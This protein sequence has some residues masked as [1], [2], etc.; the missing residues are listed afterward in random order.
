MVNTTTDVAILGAGIF[1]LAAALELR[2]RGHQVAVLDPGPIPHPLASTTDV[3]K[4]VRM[5]YGADDLYLEMVDRAIDGFEVWNERADE[6][7]YHGCGVVM[8][9]RDEMAPG[10]F[11]HD[12]YQSLL[13]HGMTPERLDADDIVR[14]FPA[15][16]PGAYKD[17]F[18]HARGGF[19]ES[20]RVVETLAGWARQ[21]GVQV[22]EGET[23]Q[24]ID[25]DSGRVTGVRTREGSHVAAGRVIIAAGAWTA[26][27]L[28]EL[29]PVMKATGHP[30]FHLEAPDPALFTPPDFAVFTADIARTGWYGF[31]QHPK[32]GIVKVA[33]HSAGLVLD[34]ENDERV[35]GDDEVEILR[36]FLRGTFPAL[37]EAPIRY[38]RRCL[39]CDTLDEHLWIDSHPELEGLVVASG[40]SGHGFKFGPVLGEL[41]ADVTEGREHPWQQRFAWRQL[42]PATAGQEPARHHV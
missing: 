27:L 22:L 5:E 17:G 38:T 1:G 10:G 39:Y 6:T 7:L 24:S 11:E 30:V 42:D 40:G 41:I 9:S 8:L 32:A 14:R 26:S 28:P 18:F 36:D 3:S 13:R 33:R 29:G 37:A 34:P 16:A 19:G 35:V 25:R 2:R 20:G 23:A 31:P 21:A 4:V 15:F 12:S